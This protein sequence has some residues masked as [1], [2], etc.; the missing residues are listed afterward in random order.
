M[1]YCSNCNNLYDISNVVSEQSGGAKN[2]NSNSETETMS[3]NEFDIDKIINMIVANQNVS[4]NNIG[5]LT[6]TQL[7]AHPSYKKLDE[8]KKEI[9]YNVILDLT[10]NVSDTKTDDNKNNLVAYYVCNNC[11]NYEKIKSGTI[12]T[13]QYVNTINISNNSDIRN[14]IMLLH[15]FT[16]P[17]SRKY[18][19]PNSKCESHSNLHLREAVF[20]RLKNSFKL[21]Y[22]CS[23]CH[24][25]W[26]V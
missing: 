24:T 5:Y 23:A 25:Y 22:V 19:C 2:T 21:I 6:I 26:N 18:V 10:T 8:K 15:D 4:K 20:K 11:G 1:L 14:P 9:V 13:K 17:R 3:D 7:I 12:L 16:L